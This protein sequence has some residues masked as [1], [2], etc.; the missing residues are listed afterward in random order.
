MK[1]FLSY[2]EE[3]TG[4]ASAIATW[5]K[6]QGFE[7]FD[8]KDPKSRGEQFIKLIEEQMREADAFLALLSPSLIRSSWCD[9]E[10]GL[11]IRREQALQEADPERSFIRVLKI[12]ETPDEDTGLLGNYDSLDLTTPEMWDSALRIL[13]DKLRRGSTGAGRASPLFRNREDELE[14]VLR[15]L[16]NP[17]GPHFW[18]VVGPPQLGKTWFLDRVRIDGALSSEPVRWV[19]RLVD[20]RELSPEA[21]LDAGVLLAHFFG[22]AAPATVEPATLRQIAQEIMRAGQPHLCLLDNAELLDEDVAITLRSS[23][24]QIHH[25]V[26]NRRNGIRVALIVAS[27]RDDEWRG[28]RPDPRLSALTLSEFKADIVQQALSDQAA[29]MRC[30]FSAAEIQRYS[31]LVRNVTGG[32]PALLVPCLRWIRAEEWLEMERLETQEL[33]ETFAEPYIQRVLLTQASLV[34][35]GQEG[36]DRS[37]QVLREVHRILAPYRFFTQSHLRHYLDLDSAFRDALEA[38]GWLMPDLW[39]AISGTALLTRPQAELWQQIHPA[40]RR[41][42]FRYFYKTDGQRADAHDEARTFIR[43]WADHQAGT[44][45]VVGLVECLWHEASML[46]LRRPGDLEQ[47]L[48]ESARKLSGALR[49]SAAYTLDEL[50]FYAVQRMKHDE[51]LQ[52]AVGDSGGLFRR[53]VDI[54]I[55][56]EDA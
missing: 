30:D 46:S 8:W 47:R 56:P 10:R 19:T 17:A 43:I 49:A 55:A 54:V 40:I 22:R 5:L 36:V 53:L 20:A 35:A 25:Y 12:A 7:L 52:E 15:G 44:E 9:R 27:R 51:E 16:T 34:P 14:R 3:D 50:R 13:A 24:S 38:S 29:E 4:T 31:V 42:L 33:F 11:A 21:R 32:L 41:L 6:Y 28:V 26:K 48:C 37:V 18:L 39:L 45:Q 1:I 2:A 23:L